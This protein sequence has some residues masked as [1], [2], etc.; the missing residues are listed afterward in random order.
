MA[1]RDPGGGY[2]AKGSERSLGLEGD[3]RFPAGRRFEGSR[4]VPGC[5][6]GASAAGWGAGAEGSW[7]ALGAGAGVGAGTGAASRG[8][9]TGG[10]GA[11]LLS[12]DRTT[13]DGRRAPL[14]ELSV[15]NT[16]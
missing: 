10:A 12:S 3:F 9:S 4:R 13:G 1:R 15:T 8:F 16:G 14:L 7:G 2:S 6:S 5:C 11:G